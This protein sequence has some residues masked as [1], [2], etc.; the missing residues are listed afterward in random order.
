MANFNPNPAP[1]RR[2]S[3]KRNMIEAQS[4]SN[5]MIEQRE[6]GNKVTNIR[7]LQPHLSN[8]AVIGLVINKQAIH[9]FPD[10]KNPG[11][12]RYKSAFTIRDSPSDYINVTC[13]GS[14]AYI[15]S[16]SSSFKIYD[17]IEICNCQVGSKPVGDSEDKWSPWTPSPFQLTLSETHSS[18]SLYN[19]VNP[20]QYMSL[21]HIPLRSTSD[22]YILSD[23]HAHWQNLDGS[24]INILAIVGNVGTPKQLMSKAGKNLTK[25]EVILFDEGC[26]S[27]SLFLWDSELITLAQTWI[28][29]ENIVFAVDVKVS[30]DSY[31]NGMTGTCTSKTLITTNPD[32]PQAHSLYQYAQTVEMDF[33]SIRGDRDTTDIHDIRDVYTVKQLS[34]FKYNSREMRM[35]GGGGI[36]FAYLMSL[37]IDCSDPQTVISSRCSS[38]K[39]RVSQDDVA[40]SNQSCPTIVSGDFA[41]EVVFDLFVTLA[42]HHGSVDGVRLNGQAAIDLL[43]ITP[44]D[45]LCTDNQ[46]R[47]LLKSTCLL[48]KYKVFI[49]SYSFG[50][51][52]KV[53]F[54]ILKIERASP[55]EAVMHL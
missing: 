17:I 47:T 18:V 16:L 26:N 27:F 39:F 43:H 40:C 50:D 5:E 36:V 48:E 8:T 31:K 30:F 53:Y 2:F 38:C 33:G 21:A 9:S 11:A 14:E 41:P 23:I 32:S 1:S 19:G 25:C 28:S 37:D 3:V 45:F 29:K 13:W 44:T 12:Y 49:K 35:K 4:T 15:S 54:N 55:R 6:I 52:S 22:Y 46:Q 7:H 24:Y 42:D 10:K 34:D 51:N 20:E